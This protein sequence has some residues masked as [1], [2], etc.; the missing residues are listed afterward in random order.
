MLSALALVAATASATAAPAP[1]HYS[2]RLCVSVSSQPANCG[3]AKAQ[4]L[5]DGDLRLRV[6]D[7]VY[8]LSFAG[9]MLV[10]VTLHDSMQVAE[11]S[12]SYRW[13][14]QTL[15]FSDRSRGLAY[16]VQLGEPTAAPA[17]SPDDDDA[18]P[19]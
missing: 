14:G 7:I 11:F 17:P 3:P 19:R 15:L 9:P 13:L 16:E 8:H 12:S 18:A 2:A 10:G 5:A 6:N 4:R 1:G